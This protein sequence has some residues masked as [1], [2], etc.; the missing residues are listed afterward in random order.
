MS[1]AGNSVR[2]P[3]LT[4]TASTGRSLGESR[5]NSRSDI[6]RHH[7]NAQR[8]MNIQECPVISRLREHTGMGTTT[9]IS[10]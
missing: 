3:S 6:K 2:T 8:I 4:T 10:V 7:Q 1:G 9:T 5:A